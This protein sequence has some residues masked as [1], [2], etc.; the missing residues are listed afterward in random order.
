LNLNSAGLIKYRSES[1]K[2]LYARNSTVTCFVVSSRT[3]VRYRARY[4]D[5]IG[6]PPLV[7]IT[8]CSQ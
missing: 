5:F 2:Q 7:E 6:S 3:N 1:K 4:Q 8:S